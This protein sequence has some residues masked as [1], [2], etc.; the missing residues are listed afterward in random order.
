MLF[1]TP[2]KKPCL[3]SND[4]NEEKTTKNIL[5]FRSPISSAQDT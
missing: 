3:I 4:E 5:K 1:L 2:T